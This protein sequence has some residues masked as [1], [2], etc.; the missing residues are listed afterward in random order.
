M[1][2]FIREKEQTELV[3]LLS[4]GNYLKLSLYLGKTPVKLNVTNYILSLNTEY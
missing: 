4:A 3:K 2:H 1:V